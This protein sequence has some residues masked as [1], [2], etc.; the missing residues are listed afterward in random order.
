MNST[1]SI[2]LS[3]FTVLM[4]FLSTLFRINI[5]IV[6]RQLVIAL[7][8]ANGVASEAA[9]VTAQEINDNWGI[10]GGIAPIRRK[11][12]SMDVRFL[13]RQGQLKATGDG[14]YYI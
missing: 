12:I 6:R 3:A 11:A 7:F 1:I 14:K 13:A 10:T 5:T 8:K 9:A 2:S 4:F